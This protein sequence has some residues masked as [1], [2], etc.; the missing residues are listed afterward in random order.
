MHLVM[1]ELVRAQMEGSGFMFGQAAA[2]GTITLTCAILYALPSTAIIGAILTTGFLGGAISAHFRL[3]EIGSP[4][5][6]VALIVGMFAW[7]GLYLRDPRLRVLLPIATSAPREGL[8]LSRRY[9]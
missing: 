1:P 2:I 9:G 3:G 8:A 4:P 5:Q 7:A 6:I